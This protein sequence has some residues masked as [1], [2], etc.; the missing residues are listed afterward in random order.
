METLT[1]RV[2]Q[3]FLREGLA[4]AAGLFDGEGSTSIARRG[5]RLAVKQ[6]EPTVLLKFQDAVGLGTVYG[7]YAIKGREGFFEWSFVVTRF[8]HVQAVVAMLWPWLGPVKRY[9]A[10]VALLHAKEALCA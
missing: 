3:T 7:P 4:W 9:Q 6:H 1:E 8:E 2:R 10:R 5:V